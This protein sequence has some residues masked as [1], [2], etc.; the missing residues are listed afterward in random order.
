MTPSAPQSMTMGTGERNAML[1][2]VL[3]IGGQESMGP[4]DVC[5]QSNAAIS[6]AIFPPPA[7]KPCGV[8]PS[9]F[10]GFP[11]DRAERA[12]VQLVAAKCDAVTSGNRHWRRGASCLARPC[13]LL[14]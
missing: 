10:I 5:D 2:L 7:R 14:A 13:R 3:R 11:K 8:A 4:S 9:I 12:A 6:S 1:M